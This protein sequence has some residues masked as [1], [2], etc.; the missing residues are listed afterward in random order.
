MKCLFHSRVY[1]CFPFRCDFGDAMDQCPKTLTT[2]T[3]N[4]CMAC[5]YNSGV[6][7]A[8]TATKIYCRKTG[9]TTPAYRSSSSAYVDYDEPPSEAAA[10]VASVSA[11][12]LVLLVALLAVILSSIATLSLMSLAPTTVAAADVPGKN[13]RASDYLHRWHNQREIEL[14]QQ[15]YLWHLLQQQQL[16]RIDKGNSEDAVRPKRQ[17]LKSNNREPGIVA[18]TFS[19][20][21]GV[22]IFIYEHFLI[23][24]IFWYFIMVHVSTQYASSF[25]LLHCLCHNFHKI[26]S[27]I[28]C[29]SKP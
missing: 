4:C 16:S 8:A 19:L 23:I 1:V 22:S 9:K 13:S 17:L 28:F 24:L 27:L 2:T 29:L 18:L 3:V 14:Q 6:T 10:F 5:C 26:L 11:A 7:T 15:S 21:G 12:A 25:S 20:I